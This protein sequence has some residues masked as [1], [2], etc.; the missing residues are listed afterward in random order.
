MTGTPPAHD[1]DPTNEGAAE[2]TE[3]E[4]VE[5]EETG[6]ELG[7]VSGGGEITDLGGDA[8]SS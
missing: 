6:E 3:V 7:E 4:P 5:D 2:P 1:A 8:P